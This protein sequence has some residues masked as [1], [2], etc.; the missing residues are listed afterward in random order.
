MQNRPLSSEL[1]KNR[2]PLS[3]ARIT[4][5]SQRGANY[6]PAWRE[7]H[8]QR[9]ANYTPS[10]ARITLPAWRELH[11]QRGAN[12]TPSVARITLQRGANYTP[13]WRELHS[14]RGANYTPS[15]ARITLPAWREL[16]SQRGANYTPSVARITLLAWRELHSQRGANYTPSVARITLPAWRELHSQRGANYTPSVARITLPAWRELHSQ[17]GANYTP[18]WRE[19]H[20]SK[21]TLGTNTDYQR[22]YLALQ[23]GQVN[24]HIFEQIYRR[25]PW[26]SYFKYNWAIMKD[27]E[28]ELKYINAKRA[29]ASALDWK[30]GPALFQFNT[31]DNAPEQ[32]AK[33]TEY[34]S[35]PSNYK[36]ANIW[37]QRN[38]YIPNGIP[39]RHTPNKRDV[40]GLFE[41][42]IPGH[43]YAYR[44]TK[45][46][47]MA[48][49]RRSNQ[50]KLPTPCNIPNTD[51]E[52]KCRE[53]VTKC[54]DANRT[55]DIQFLGD[56][57][58]KQLV[59]WIY[60]VFDSLNALG[61]PDLPTIGERYI[62]YYNSGVLMLSPKIDAITKNRCTVL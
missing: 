26:Q 48:Q 45:A 57:T 39:M 43:N 41:I 53:M 52:A 19:L 27:E 6:T 58:M 36:H 28:K 13:A 21:P 40:A 9:G 25:E 37:L 5:S 38:E 49:D 31:S 42:D 61:I 46:N 51:I 17:R 32:A 3:V 30:C 18:A 8:S 23:P 16:H 62:P 1:K 14:Q 11:S 47:Q 56:S 4:L 29:S 55:M 24:C 7:L 10:V 34:F 12:Y 59:P 33:F 60:M 50:Q 54:P 35:Q 44:E 15:V 2:P 20:S 22:T